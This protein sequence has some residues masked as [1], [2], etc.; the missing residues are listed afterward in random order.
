MTALFA[1]VLTGDTYQHRETLKYMGFHWDAGE[2]V[3]CK[4]EDRNSLD[5]NTRLL[6]ELKRL[7]GVT[8]TVE[9]AAR[10]NVLQR[11]PS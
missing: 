6:R 8:V 10:Y 5:A 3:W 7:R 2:R 11:F 1:Y 9:K 4:M